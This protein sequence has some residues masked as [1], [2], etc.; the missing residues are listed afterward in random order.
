MEKLKKIFL[1]IFKSAFTINKEIIKSCEKSENTKYKHIKFRIFIFFLLIPILYI[2]L[3]GYIRDEFSVI[4]IIRTLLFLF[5]F[6]VIAKDITDTIIVIFFYKSS[7][8][9]TL[10]DIRKRK[11]RKLNR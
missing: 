2:L 3:F 10:K 4:N 9:Y 5:I 7:Y 11:L 1:F 8:K 6:R